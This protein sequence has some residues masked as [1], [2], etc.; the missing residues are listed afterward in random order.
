[1]SDVKPLLFRDDLKRFIDILVL[2]DADDRAKALNANPDDIILC[3]I[4]RYGI[5]NKTAMIAPLAELYRNTVLPHYSRDRRWE[6]SRHVAEMVLNADFV[7]INAMLPFIA[8]DD[9]R[10]IVATAII[11]YVSLGPLTADDPMSRPKDIIGMLEGGVL[12]NDGAAFGAL[13]HMGDARICKLLWPLRYDLSRD[14]VDEAIKCS[15]GFLYSAA[16]EFEIDWLEEMEGDDR[17]GLFGLVASGLVLQKKA[18][19]HD[20]VFTGQ[21]PFPIPRDVSAEEQKRNLELAVPISVA[22]YTGRIAPRLYALERTEPP[23]RVMPHVLMAWGLKPITEAS[24]SAAVDDRRQSPAAVKPMIPGAI[25]D[26]E[27]VEIADEWSDG[28]GSILLCWGILNPN[29]PTLYC[30]GQRKINGRKRVFFRWMHMLGG[31]TYYSARSVEELSYNDIFESA[32]GIREFLASR[33][34]PTPFNTIPSFIISNGNDAT[35]AEIAKELIK[36]DAAAQEDW[37]REISYLDAFGADFFARA[38]SEIRLFFETEKSN[39]IKDDA[40]VSYL[41]FIEARYGHIP[42]FANA[43]FPAFRSSALTDEFFDK[44]WSTIETPKHCLVGFSQLAEMWKGAA[45]M[46]P[47]DRAKTA[48]PFER[49]IEFLAAYQFELPNSPAGG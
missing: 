44:W 22:E 4:L 1:M 14:A 26:G 37:G 25:P 41:Q 20:L 28:E 24:E 39:P 8:E 13:L 6:L 16:V 7:S 19:R 38:G 2:D 47:Q 30:L 48:I 32:L 43:I 34:I 18:N 29:G 11:D 23:P 40:A 35:L 21:R 9:D 5:L 46:L 3:E 31:R 36:S 17:D 27:V 10:Q 42:A 45:S 12:K 33:Q 49:I 15:T